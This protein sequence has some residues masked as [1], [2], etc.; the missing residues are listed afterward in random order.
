MHDNYVFHDQG[1]RLPAENAIATPMVLEH[2]ERQITAQDS[3]HEHGKESY[4]G[5][6]SSPVT[7]MISA[8]NYDRNRFLTCIAH[9]DG[10]VQKS[11]PSLYNHVFYITPNIHD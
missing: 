1:V 7:L 9:I 10:A 8:Y 11:F 6:V 4:C 5:K 2:D 3:K